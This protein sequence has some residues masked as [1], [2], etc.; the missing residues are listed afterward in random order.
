MRRLVRSALVLAG[1]LVP[2]AAALADPPPKKPRKPGDFDFGQPDPARPPATEPA[3]GAPRTPPVDGG[4]EDPLR[5]VFEDLATW[6]SRQGKHAAETLML[7]GPDVSERLLEALQGKNLALQ[8]GA[9]WVLGQ[10][11]E[12]AHVKPIL[13]AAANRP[14]GARAEIFFDAAYQLSPDATKNWL[15]GFLPLDRPGFRDKAVEFLSGKVGEKDRERVVLLLD[16]E[17][18][19]V[20]IAGLRLLEPAGVPDVDER[21]L[22]AL[23]DLAPPVAKSATMLLAA[24]RTPDLPK[25]L[26]ALAREGEA[27]ERAYATLALVET[28]RVEGASVLETA[29]LIDLLG[30]RGLLHPEK[31]TRAA[32]AVGLAIGGM[33]SEDRTLLALLDSTV[34]EVLIDA[35]GGDHYRDYQSVSEP[36]FTSL[37]RL[38]GLDLPS[39]A[40]AWAR[41]WQGER[42]KFHARRPLRS[43]APDDVLRAFVRFESVEANGAR[44]TVEF[45]PK[46]GAKRKDAYI[47]SRPAFEALLEGLQDA[48]IFA[49]AKPD[50]PRADEHLAVTLGV[51]NQEA[52]LVAMPGPTGAYA[53][54]KVRLD[55][56]EETNLW[57]RYRDQDQWP[58]AETWWEKNADLMV[59]AS[60]EQRR[61]L[62]QA[63]IVHAFDDL[64]GDAARAEALDRIES[65]GAGLSTSEARAL[66]TGATASPAF[67]AVEARAVRIAIAGDAKGEATEDALAALADRTEAD[68][69]QIVADLLVRGGTA[70]VRTAFADTRAGMR[71][72]AAEAAALLVKRAPN[73]EARKAAADL[74]RPGL[75]VVS[76]DDD[77]RAAI[78]ALKAL[79]VLGD[80]GVVAKLEEVYKKGDLGLKLTVAEALGSIPG[81]GAHPLLTLILAEPDTER[82]GALRAAALRSM[83]ATRHPNSIRLLGFY[84][85]SDP[86]PSVKAAAAD[87]LADLGTEEARFS[88]IDLLTRGEADGERRAR[89][90][91]VLGRFEGDVVSEMLASYLA[92]PD[93]RV[94]AVA[95]LRGGRRN[96]AA[97]VPSLVG[98]LRTGTDAQ[99]EEALAGLESTTSARMPGVGYSQKADQYD[100]WYAAAKGGDDRAWFREALVARGYE[101]G[102]LASYLKGGADLDAVPLLLRVLRD[103]DPVLRRNAALALR[104]V[105]GLS[106]GSLDRGLSAGEW[107][108]I[109][110]LW[111]RWWESEGKARAR[112][113]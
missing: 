65:L 25:R 8:P 107:T 21:L 103:E 7:R 78:Q 70:R 72:A 40:V 63:S 98:L 33:E 76:T 46:G 68:A 36:A 83:A 71:A 3:G 92:D 5:E 86:D 23:D 6:P 31:L 60:P 88:V 41:W 48:G 1:L 11:G 26:N 111:S 58:D 100:Q 4:G 19:W 18:S 55:A 50:R 105:T 59:Q 87:A 43:V 24:R 79:A 94:A 101:A 109:A 16:S 84:L 96:L 47:L 27:R 9:A 13:T 108:R 39:N 99:R 75:E 20:R 104:R 74:V 112:G 22:R 110:D 17:K 38:S 90:V 35:V 45:V 93:P 30:R 28:S 44:R 89:L 53:V 97:A 34:V 15:F 56:L 66:V 51:A 113:R 73:A 14:N 12:P 64:A 52:R 95:A 81:D 91:D 29:T 102:P 32:A 82:T 54:L 49:G 10:V 2:A 37:R 61:L 106:F 85:L 42:G 57:Q 62:L 67:G 77:P 69:R 80:A